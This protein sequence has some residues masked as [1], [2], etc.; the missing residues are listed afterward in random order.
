MPNLIHINNQDGILTVS[1]RQVAEDFEKEHFNVVR[2]IENLIGGIINFEDTLKL[3]IETKY[4]HEQNKQWY[5]EYLLTRDGFSLLVMGFTGQRALEWKLKYIEAFSKMEEYIRA[6]QKPTCIE[7]VMIQS[8]QEMKAMKQQ[9]SEAHSNA[10]T[11]KTEAQE[12]KH[13]LQTMRDVIALDTTSW[14]RDTTIIINRI[15]QKLGGN[16]HIRDVRKEAYA[17]LDKRM[18]VD[19]QTRLTNKRR[20]MADEGVCKS[21]R[22]KLNQLDVIADD[23]KLIEGFVAIVKQMAVK[24]GVAEGKPA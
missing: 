23:K 19:I 22:D 10:L 11:A 13:E 8:L 5:K 9:L 18:G 1:S 6:Q 24:Y 21:K 20:R 17:L 4:Q 7:D 15:A 2:D 14:R 16:E 12:V 3:F